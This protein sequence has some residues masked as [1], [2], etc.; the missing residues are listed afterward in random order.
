MKYLIIFLF[1]LGCGEN[2]GVSP[3]GGATLGPK[4]IFATTLTGNG[5]IGGIGAAD[6]LCATSTNNPG[7][8]LYKALLVDGFNRRACSTAHCSGGLSE[9][10]DWVLSPNTE[11]RRLSDNAPIAITNSLG[12]F[13][14]NL[15]NSFDSV[16]PYWYWT[17]LS[18][19]WTS[20]QTCAGWTSTFGGGVIGRS[21]AEDTDAIIA[22]LSSCE[23]NNSVICVEQ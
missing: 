21:N 10:I 17:G 20:A 11:Y 7:D 5:N 19:D 3:L 9:Q 16:P 12:L 23:I 4:K 14:F 22:T 18:A 6:S 1:L 13:T 2:S 8:G 15:I